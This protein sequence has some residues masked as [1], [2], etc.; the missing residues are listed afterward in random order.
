MCHQP[1][2]FDA[3]YG[4]LLSFSEDHYFS[5]MLSI[6]YSVQISDFLLSSIMEFQS[7]TPLLL[8]DVIMFIQ[9]R[10]YFAL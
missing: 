5:N 1:S 8:S 2:D 9:V 3:I 6:N 7:M 10:T 4:P